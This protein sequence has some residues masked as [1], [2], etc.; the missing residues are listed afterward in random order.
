MM[1]NAHIREDPRATGGNY[2]NKVENINQ[3]PKA[4]ECHSYQ[5]LKQ[6]QGLDV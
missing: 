4:G 1:E 5:F 6:A 2:Q 3:M